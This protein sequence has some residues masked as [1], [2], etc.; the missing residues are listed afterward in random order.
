MIQDDREIER[1]FKTA[2]YKLLEIKDSDIRLMTLLQGKTAVDRGIHIGGAFSATIPL[3][4]LY[5][6]GV[7]N[8]DVVNPTAEGQDLFVL[9]KG[10]AIA[11]LASIYAD[12]GYFPQKTLE[13]SRSLESILNGHPG[14]ILPGIHTATGP[15]GQGICVA[16]GFAL[17]TTCGR[18]SDVFCLT[19]DGELQEGVVWEAVMY[20]GAKRLENLCVMIDKNEGQLDSTRSLTYSMANLGDAF[21]SF[22]WKVIDVD[23]TRYET[24]VEGLKEFKYGDRDGRPTL[25]I[26]NGRKGWGGISSFM[27]GHK[28]DFPDAIAD[29]EIAMQEDRRAMRVKDLQALVSSMVDTEEK[30]DLKAYIADM[31]LG[32]NLQSSF[33]KSGTLQVKPGK[34]TVKLKKAPVRDKRIKWVPESLPGYEPGQSVAAQDVVTSSMKVF[35]K[36]RRVMSVDSDLAVISGLEAGIGYVDARRALN[37]GIAEAN[38]MCVGESFAAMGYNAWVSTFSPFFDWKVLRRIAVSHEERL[39][40]AGKDGWLAEGHG[41]DLTFLATAPNLETKTNGATHMGND[42]SLVYEG[43]AHLKIIDAC[44]PNQL[45]SIMKWIMEGN[46]GLV[47]LRILRSG[48]PAIYDKNYKFEFGKA[49]AFGDVKNPD[50]YIVSSGRGVFEAMS[51]AEMLKNKGIK[52]AIVDMPSIDA[53]MINKLHDSGKKV[54]VAEQNNGYIW[55]NM[56]KVLFGKKAINTTNLVPMNLL[57]EKGEARFIH[58]ATYEQLLNLYGVSPRQIAEK[59]ETALK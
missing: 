8:Y 21:E 56:Q 44:C 49:A 10:H 30:E 2:A 12:L 13:N 53:E 47:Y 32:M 17:E 52:T 38:M 1:I 35:A 11:A 31:C 37:V 54:I 22:G 27:G 26:C 6:S 4:S 18:A 33:T 51:A 9:S 45:L 50:V 55:R 36:D 58:S 40:A 34:C 14:S 46:K 28:V 16:E 20:A 41:L 5:Y 19:G 15:L 29:Q 25:I 48:T 7:M 42:D 59:I 3:V 43:V 57:D 39:H 24:V 23:A